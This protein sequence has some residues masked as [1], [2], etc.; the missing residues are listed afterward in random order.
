M[1]T[2]DQLWKGHTCALALLLLVSVIISYSYCVCYREDGKPGECKVG[3]ATEAY[4]NTLEILKDVVKNQK[5]KRRLASLDAS[6]AG[7]GNH[8]EI[9]K[10]FSNFFHFNCFF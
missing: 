9:Y 7:L 8:T 2:L 10:V 5:D 4:E 6:K 3:T 1:T